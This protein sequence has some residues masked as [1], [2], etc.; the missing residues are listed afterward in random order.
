MPCRSTNQERKKKKRS[1]AKRKKRRPILERRRREVRKKNRRLA[2][3]RDDV[4]SQLEGDLLVCCKVVRRI[5]LGILWIK[6][7]EDGD[8]MKKGIFT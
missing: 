5:E 3:R 8:M 6:E 2:G 7:R 4:E 1:R